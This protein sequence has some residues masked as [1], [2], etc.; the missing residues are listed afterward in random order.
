MTYSYFL[1]VPPNHLGLKKAPTRVFTISFAPRQL[2]V[3]LGPVLRNIPPGARYA[4]EWVYKDG[5]L[6]PTASKI[7][8]NL[9]VGEISVKYVCRGVVV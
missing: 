8:W 2:A 7:I 3:K 9:G 5:S 6:R 1:G 4:G